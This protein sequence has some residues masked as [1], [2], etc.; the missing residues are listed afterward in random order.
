MLNLILRSELH[1]LTLRL[2]AL[3]KKFCHGRVK[4]II[5]DA[6]ALGRRV[7]FGCD[8]T[9]VQTLTINQGSVASE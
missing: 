2:I 8:I 3:K 1:C 4:K 5:M 6:A 7:K 9:K